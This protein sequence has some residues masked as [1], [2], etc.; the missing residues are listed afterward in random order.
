MDRV[1]TKLA[2]SLLL[3]VLGISCSQTAEFAGGNGK[4]NNEDDRQP[5]PDDLDQTKKIPVVVAQEYKSTVLGTSQVQLN[6]NY[7]SIQNN[8]TLQSSFGPANAELNQEVRAIQDRKFTQGTKRKSIDEKFKQTNYGILDILVVVDNS[9]SMKEEHDKLKKRLPE[10]LTYIAASDWR[11]GIISTDEKDDCL[12][13]LILNDDNNPIE[14]FEK[15]INRLGTNGN[16]NEVGILQAVKGLNCKVYERGRKVSWLRDNSNVGVLIV[17]DED[18]CSDG[19]SEGQTDSRTNNR[20]CFTDNN[21]AR[22]AKPYRASQYLTTFLKDLRPVTKSSI[23]GIMWDP[24][25]PHDACADAYHP[26]NIYK[27]AITATKGFIGSICDDS[28]GKTMEAISKSLFD[29]LQSTFSLK[30]TPRA[31]TILVT[32]D[33]VDVTSNVTITDRSV[34]FN[35]IPALNSE[36][37]IHY[38][39]TDSTM[40]KEFMVDTDL[41]PTTLEV[42]VNDRQVRERDYTWNPSTGILT[43][44]DYPDDSASIVVSYKPL[45][46]LKKVFNLDAALGASPQKD[47]I[48]VEVNGRRRTDFEYNPQNGTLTFTNVPPEGA[49]IKVSCQKNEGPILKYPMTIDSRSVDSVRAVAADDP[50]KIYDIKYEDG[51]ILIPESQ[52]KEGAVVTVSYHDPATLQQT[53]ALPQEPILDTIVVDPGKNACAPGDFTVQKQSVSTTCPLQEGEPVNISYEYPLERKRSFTMDGVPDPDQA[54]WTVWVDQVERTDYQRQGATITFQ[55]DLPLNAKVLIQASW[56]TA[57][58]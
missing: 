44:D 33:G 41:D 30:F 40:V 10:L 52:F 49:V 50:N 4:K 37:K 56:I 17:S 18:N 24:A 35:Q 2:A 55:D 31:G 7:N 47:T 28:Y 45:S 11:V 29:S 43:F 14:K 42:R 58:P 20:T 39:I 9:G 13:E 1:T 36:I 34:T 27:E 23:F 6:A 32:V 16:G 51:H 57:A 22:T 8:L 54:A 26:G 12:R 38:D 5:Q 46:G 19:N 21:G 53:V 48:T 25:T 15:A 3:G